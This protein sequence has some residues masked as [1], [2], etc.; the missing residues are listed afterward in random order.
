[1]S[2][3]T[4]AHGRVAQWL[5]P[6]LDAVARRFLGPAR[7]RQKGQST[8]A[9]MPETA[10]ARFRPSGRWRPDGAVLRKEGGGER[11][12]RPWFGSADGSLGR[13]GCLMSRVGTTWKGA[14]QRMGRARAKGR[15]GKGPKPDFSLSWFLDLLLPLILV[16]KGLNWGYT[17]IAMISRELRPRR[18]VFREA[19]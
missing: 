12:D 6:G 2:N 19:F 4:R 8:V 14:K 17:L 1:M 16:H 13:P 9:R 5:E 11:V 7:V 3:T 10:A 18:R 15:R